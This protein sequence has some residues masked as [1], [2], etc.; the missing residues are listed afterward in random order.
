MVIL[1][2]NIFQKLSFQKLYQCEINKA[3]EKKKNTCI[4]NKLSVFISYN[5]I[6]GQY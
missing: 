1:N 3:S 6:F 4:L 5:I 2:T